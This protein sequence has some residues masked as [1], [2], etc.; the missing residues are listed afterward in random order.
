M[1]IEITSF[2]RFKKKILGKKLQIFNRNSTKLL[3]IC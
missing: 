3:N 2:F 1:K